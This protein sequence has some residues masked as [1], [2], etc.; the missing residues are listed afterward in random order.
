V[1]HAVRDDGNTA[2]KHVRR[3]ATDRALTPGKA[4]R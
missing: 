4:G 2:D 1:A 3:N